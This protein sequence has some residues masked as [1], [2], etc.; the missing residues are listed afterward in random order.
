MFATQK[1]RGAARPFTCNRKHPRGRPWHRLPRQCASVEQTPGTDMQPAA[2][3]DYGREL[4]LET[5][6]PGVIAGLTELSRVGR[7]PNHIMSA[8]SHGVRGRR[9][10]HVHKSA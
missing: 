4:I 3:L 10:S 1:L 8:A 2:E 7:D 5:R 6:D 9:S